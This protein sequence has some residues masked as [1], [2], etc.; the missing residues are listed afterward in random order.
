MTVAEL[1]AELAKY[2]DDLPVCVTWE[3]IFRTPSVYL[4]PPHADDLPIGVL[5]I[6]A[7]DDRYRS[8]IESGVIV[9]FF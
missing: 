2:P 7:D 1:R 4:A 6:D 9:P 8:R 3:S 5:V